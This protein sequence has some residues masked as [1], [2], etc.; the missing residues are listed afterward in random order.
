MIRVLLS[1][2]LLVPALAWSQAAG[3]VLMAVGEVVAERGTA[4]VP[5]ALNSQ[6]FP[7]DT[8]RLGPSSNAQI[9][10][11]DE[12][13]VGLRERSVFRIDEYQYAQGEGRSVFSL[14]AGGMRTVTGRIG[15]LANQRGNYAVRTPTS[16]IGIRGTHY[17]V[18]HCNNDC[19]NAKTAS[20]LLASASFTTSDAGL[21]AQAPG[22]TGGDVPNG[23]YGGVTDGRISAAPNDAPQFLREFGHDEY[24]HVAT[25][26]SQPQSL[27]APPAFLHDRLSGQNRASGQSGKESGD[28][29]AQGGINAE[30]RP[31]SV[32]EGPRPSDF[33]VTEQKTSTG[34]S[35][36]VPVSRDTAFLATWITP[37]SNND[38]AA[39]G[40]L[41]PQ[42]ALSLG[43]DGHLNA[44]TVGAGCVGAVQECDIGVS[45]TLNTALE[46]S[47]ATFPNSTQ[48]VFW[49]RWNSGTLNDGGTS[50]TLS[51]ATQGHFMYAPLTPQDTIAA[52]T[53][54]LSLQS[55]FPGGYGT[56]P[57]N[58]F[59]ATPVG[60][61]FPTLSVNFTSR[62]ISVGSS[63][64]N[65]ADAGSGTQNWS[66][67]SNSGTLVLANGGAYFLIDG[68]GSCTSGGTACNGGPSFAAK[69][70]VAGIF[71]G[72]AGDHAGVAISG[73]AGTSQ[74]S[75][76]R[77]YC[78]TC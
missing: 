71:I 19:G 77:V 47:S 24:F 12:S 33:I 34:T 45:G 37:G 38:L 69:G 44:F 42:S 13:I 75:T 29:L 48:K 26:D 6:I 17:T 60:G 73:A 30:S 27:I 40:V 78:P 46:E 72:P 52:K 3:R 68:T 15:R 67:G 7:G 8:I 31:G 28:T 58:N 57:T 51:T 41:I 18:V 56:T 64:I 76:V 55:T 49:G 20:A 23:T 50:I 2:L 25:A 35:T 21:L 61:S 53:G 39:A 65:F 74:F 22:G 10:L 5:L 4:T 36:V 9:R 63:F 43:S 1:L 70:R 14:L 54:M 66:F 11:T 32:P 16:T 59:G 62:A